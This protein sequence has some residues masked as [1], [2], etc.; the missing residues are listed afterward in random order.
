MK[1]YIVIGISPW[2]SY[3]AK[4]WFSRYRPKCCQPNKL[5]GSLKCNIS[6]NK[7]MMKFIFCMQVNI[8]FFYKSIPS[9]SVCVNRH[10]ECTQNKRFPHF[11]NIYRKAWRLVDFSPAKMHNISK[12]LEGWS[13]FFACSQ[14]SIIFSKWCYHFRCVWP[15]MPNL[16]KI[17][18]LLFLCNMLRKKW[19]MKLIFCM[20]TSMK[21]CYKLILWF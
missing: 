10:I 14:T 16:P 9:N 12:K 19:V 7:G 6:R 5:Q 8:K 13:W 20:Q 3:L 11:C 15:V 1:T 21:A 2:I 17:K 4:F 18:C